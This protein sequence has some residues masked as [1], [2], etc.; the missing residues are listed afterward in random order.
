[1]RLRQ[2]ALRQQIESIVKQWKSADLCVPE[3]VLILHSRSALAESAIGATD[4][5][6]GI[7]FDD[8]QDVGQ[9]I[10]HCSPHKAKGLDSKAVVLVGVS[11][12]EVDEMSSYDRFTLFMGASRQILAVISPLRTHAEFS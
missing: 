4:H 7:L 11:A 5:L 12:P 9:G 8:Y 10:R 1:V 6:G 3:E 2:L